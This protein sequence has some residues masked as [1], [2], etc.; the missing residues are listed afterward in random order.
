[1][2]MT[3]YLVLDNLSYREHVGAKA[4]CRMLHLEANIILADCEIPAKQPMIEIE[5]IEVHKPSPQSASELQI[6]IR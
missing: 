2:S 1:M 5:D 4:R 3:S 6:S